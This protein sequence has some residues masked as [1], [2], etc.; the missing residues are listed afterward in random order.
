M[1]MITLNAEKRDLS[2]NNKVLRKEGKMPAVFYGRKVSSTAVSVSLADFKKVWSDAG[3]SS[4]ITLKTV[5]GDLDALI[6]DVD[7]DPL[8][9]EPRHA[10][11]Y[12]VDKDKK[13]VVSVPL[14][15][16]GESLAVKNLNGI[17]I[18]VMHEIEVEVLPKD[19]PHNIE[20]NI[21]LLKELDNHIA[22]SD[23][24]IPNSVSPKA[25]LDEVVASISVQKEEE[26]STEA[27]VDISSVEVEKKGKK[28]ESPAVSGD[29]VE[30]P[31]TSGENTK[32][33][34]KN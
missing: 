10:D 26:V 3:E 4:V 21:S 17:L 18:K 24:K 16:V 15:F 9:S 27:E 33:T 8:K 28:D 29:E 22:V 7:I 14:K 2:K 11:F 5:E 13:I 32:E 23:L 31:A 30:N 6:Y 25:S 34:K 1:I 12:I 20:V 19:L